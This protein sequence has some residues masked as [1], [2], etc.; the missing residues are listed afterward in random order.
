[1][2]AVH[3]SASGNGF[4][5]CAAFQPRPRSS[6][7]R[8]FVSRAPRRGPEPVSSDRTSR[9]LLRGDHRC[10]TFAEVPFPALRLIRR[11]QPRW[12]NSSC[13]CWSG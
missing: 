13:Y 9:F 11:R 6:R 1:V 7:A 10:R 8:T 5:N 3:V 4:D 2:D 12:R